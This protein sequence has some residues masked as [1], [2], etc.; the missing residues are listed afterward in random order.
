MR[1]LVLVEKNLK[2]RIKKINNISIVH[3]LVDNSGL[4][5]EIERN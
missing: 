1:I 2:V 5:T 4:S 3:F